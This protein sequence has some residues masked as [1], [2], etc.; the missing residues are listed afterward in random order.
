ME[1]SAGQATAPDGTVLGYR[2][3][4][5]G[6]TLVL[7]HAT[8]SDARQWNRLVP[9]LAGTFRVV[10]MDRRGRGA[11]GPFRPDHSIEVEYDD[12]VA[13]AMAQPGPVHLMGHSSGARFALHAA[14]RIPGLVSLILYEPPA[15]E[16][17]PDRVMESFRRLE[18][19]G[20]RRGILH[21]FF[22]GVLGVDEEAFAALPARPIWPLMLDNALTLP[23]ELRA[24]RG[25]RFNPAD[26]AGLTTPT[27]LLLGEESEDDVAAV[28]SRHATSLPANTVVSL[29]GQAHGAMFSGP[30]L[31]AAEILRFLGAVPR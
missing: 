1:G 17:L 30:E 21:Q 27:L 16:V 6:E 19:A 18:L 20:D 26:V 7:V 11:S 5:A 15:P 24:V 2:V 22:V 8:A 4:G 31:L 13:V 9:L 23:P 12:V 14:S 10:S 25:Y 3:A 29:P 28:L